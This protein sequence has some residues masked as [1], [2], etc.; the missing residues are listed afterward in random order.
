MSLISGHGGYITVDPTAA[1]VEVLD[2]TL[3][4]Q[5]RLVESTNSGSQGTVRRTSILKDG[6]FTVNLQYDDAQLPE[7]DVSLDIGDTGTMVLHIGDSGKFYSFPYIIESVQPKSDSANASLVTC[8]ITGYV[9]GA[10]TL[11]TT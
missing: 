4:R 5:A 2:W 7:V 9:N 1:Q 3:N 8:T 11:P 6:S 10:V